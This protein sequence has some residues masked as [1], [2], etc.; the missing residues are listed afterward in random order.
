MK[1]FTIE[2]NLETNKSSIK[3]SYLEYCM[4]NCLGKQKS[5]L[6]KERFYKL[7]KNEQEKFNE[8]VRA[9]K[10][11]I[12][13]AYVLGNQPFFNYT[14]KVNN[15]VLIPRSETEIMVS[16][17]LNCGDKIYKQSGNVT[18]LDLGAGSGCIGLTI[19]AERK[20]WNVIL[21][22]KFYS[23]ADTIRENMSIL[24]VNNCYF[25]IMDWLSGLKNNLADIIVSNPPYI[26]HQ[27]ILIDDNVKNFEPNTALF[28]GEKG[29]SDIKKIIKSSQETLKENG[30]LFLENGYDQSDEV[31][32]LLREH[33]YR[34]IQV[35]MD[36]NNI[37]RFTCS[38]KI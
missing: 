19:A 37:H 22:E 7:K 11:S 29:L 30:Y 26:E 27:S 6:F 10:S 28:S 38:R 9:L 13:V 36:Y 25:I 20:N 31:V 8:M 33:D 5:F 16:H 23:C 3:K 4:M 15:N 32:N 21:T 12:P 24:K 1:T 34:D 2:H 17:I 35:L 14:F 18:V